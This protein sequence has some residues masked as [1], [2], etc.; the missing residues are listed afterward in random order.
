MGEKDGLH[1]GNIYTPLQQRSS[2]TVNS[3][4]IIMATVFWDTKGIYQMKPVH[5]LLSC[6]FKIH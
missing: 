6:F 3:V 5:A 1:D 4:C 2:K